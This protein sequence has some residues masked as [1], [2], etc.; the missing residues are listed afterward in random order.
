MIKKNS[1]RTV[2]IEVK[3]FTDMKNRNWKFEHVEFLLLFFLSSKR[4][5]NYF[6][7]D[8]S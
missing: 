8:I 5:L 6:T 3:I 7:A 1:Q 4:H 2:D